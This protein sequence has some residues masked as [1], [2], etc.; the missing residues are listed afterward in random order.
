M[1]DV[2]F[3]RMERQDIT[4][5]FPQALNYG[6]YLSVARL[7]GVT[8]AEPFRTEDVEISFTS[9]SRRTALTGTPAAARLTRLLDLAMKDVS[10]P[11]QGVVLTEALAKAL[12]VRRGNMVSLTFLSRNRQTIDVPVSAITQG[13]FGLGAYMDMAALNTLLHQDSVVSGVYVSFDTA[14]RPALLAALKSMPA[15]RFVVFQKLVQ[16][17]FKETLAQ[18]ISIMM[19]VYVSLASIVAFGVIYNFARVSL[20][21]QGRELAS[22]RVIG[23]TRAEVSSFLLSEL[24]VIVVIAQ[25]LGWMIGTGSAYAMTHAFSSELYRVPLIINPSVYASASLIVIAA[26]I[27]SALVVRRRIDALDLVAVLKTRE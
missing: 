24:A 26:A 15:T 6:A 12:A 3:N 10:L 1:V 4:I 20:S 19:T 27:L 18:N 25:P 17:R 23:F 8:Q 9:K 14:Q 2:T 22:L 7:P 11:P 21:E 13:Y 5:Q 16:Q